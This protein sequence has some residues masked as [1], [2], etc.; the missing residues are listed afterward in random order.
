M[1]CPKCGMHQGRTNS[2]VSECRIGS[3]N[4]SIKRRRICK[5]GHKF[6]TREYTTKDLEELCVLR[7]MLLPKQVADV[8][9]GFVSNMIED[10][11]TA[12]ENARKVENVL[13]K[14]R[15]NQKT[16]LFGIQGGKK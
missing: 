1:D 6:S 11:K 12:L 9:E 3:N 13:S 2:K 14:Y 8:S 7:D 10:L 5:C 15:K 4:A 16:I